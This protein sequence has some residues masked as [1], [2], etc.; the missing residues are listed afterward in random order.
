MLPYSISHVIMKFDVAIVGSGL[1]GLS[2]ALH[3]AETR[4]VAIISK[5]AL[6]DGASNWAQGGIA[7]V[8]DSGDS[9]TQHIDDTLVAG[10][11]LCDE[12]ATRYIV[13]HGREAGRE[14]VRD[15]VEKVQDT[16]IVQDEWWRQE[17]DRQ[18]YNLLLRSGTVRTVYHDRLTDTWYEQA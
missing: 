3:L 9:H 7:A 13:E 16:W 5:R 10:G 14:P 4:T 1:A 8:L 15:A 18:Y 11:G 2:V 17:I 6:K 12:G